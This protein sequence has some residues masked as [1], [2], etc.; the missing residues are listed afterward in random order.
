MRIGEEGVRKGNLK[1]KKSASVSACVRFQIGL[2][3]TGSSVFK[4]RKTKK[5]GEKERTRC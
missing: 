3:L 5:A 2:Y 1:K 4:V